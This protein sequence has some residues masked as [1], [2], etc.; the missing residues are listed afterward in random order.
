[1]THHQVLSLWHGKML[2]PLHAGVTAKGTMERVA[3][4]YGLTFADLVSMDRSKPVSTARHDAVWT[5]RQIKAPDGRPRY[6]WT[7]LG[8]MLG[9]RD[10]T[11]MINSYKR[12]AETLAAEAVAA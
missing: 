5:C 9:S 6:S 3:A 2:V 12:H 10:H 7:F 11:T 4:A 1:M 8:N